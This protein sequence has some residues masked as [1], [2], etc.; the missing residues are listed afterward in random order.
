MIIPSNKSDDRKIMEVHSTEQGARGVCSIGTARVPPHEPGSNERWCTG[1]PHFPKLEI[2][3]SIS[4]QKT[5]RAT[6]KQGNKFEGNIDAW[7]TCRNGREASIIGN[8]P[9]D[10]NVRHEMD[11]GILLFYSSPTPLPLPALLVPG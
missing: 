9:E 11:N 3:T 6:F 7:K 2:E 5:S 4:F 8:G 1:V 10:H